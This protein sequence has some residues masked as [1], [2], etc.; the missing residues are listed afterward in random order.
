[1]KQEFLSMANILKQ[2][3]QITWVTAH[4]NKLQINM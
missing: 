4:Q 3:L 2:L 1:M